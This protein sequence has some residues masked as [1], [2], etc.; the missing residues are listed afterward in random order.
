MSSTSSM[1]SMSRLMSCEVQVEDKGLR[2]VLAGEITESSDF[3]ALLPRLAGR[4]VLDLSGIKRINSRGVRE[5]VDFVRAAAGQGITLE[6]DR[7]SVPVVHQL[8]LNAAFGGQCAVR[9]VYA[10]YFCPVCNA[11]HAQLVTLVS[12]D[13]TSPAPR[14]RIVESIPCP[15][16]AAPMEFDDLPDR[17]LSF[18]NG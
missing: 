3:G 10:P 8:N 7:C 4:V 16:C 13:P 9:S 2:A 15:T 12:A 6:L 5:W 14:P 17:Y 18:Q 1:S 11:E